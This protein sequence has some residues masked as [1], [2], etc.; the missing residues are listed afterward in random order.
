MADRVSVWL[1]ARDVVAEGDATAVLALGCP[2]CGG[3]LTIKFVPD[4]PQSDG[5][6]A[7]LIKVTCWACTAGTYL[8]GRSDPPQ[9]VEALG[10]EVTTMPVSEQGRQN[11][12]T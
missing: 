9:W 4:S 11:P 1:R 7:G 5:T 2:K 8:D 10:N 12:A 6:V 3:S